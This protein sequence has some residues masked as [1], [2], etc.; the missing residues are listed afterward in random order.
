MLFLL[1]LYVADPATCLASN[2]VLEITG[3]NPVSL[4]DWILDYCH[5]IVYFV[6]YMV[7]QNK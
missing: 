5:L 6:F 4:C 3:I 7:E 2:S 1:C